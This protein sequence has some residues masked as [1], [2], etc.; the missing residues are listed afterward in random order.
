MGMASV[1]VNPMRLKNRSR[2]IKMIIA[3]AGPLGNMVVMLGC[4]LFIK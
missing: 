3:F 2:D 1:P 4:W